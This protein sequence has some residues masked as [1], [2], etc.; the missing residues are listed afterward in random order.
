MIYHLTRREYCVTI[1]EDTPEDKIENN[2]IQLCE[3]I[4]KW[5][6]NKIL[7]IGDPEIEK[8]IKSN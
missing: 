2:I 1:E 5:E 6:V 7:N 4:E 8:L 3:S